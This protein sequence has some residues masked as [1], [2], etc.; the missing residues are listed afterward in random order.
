MNQA[1]VKG[2]APQKKTLGV[3]VSLSELLHLE[4]RPLELTR[5]L[6][7]I[8]PVV[9]TVVLDAFAS[10]AFHTFD[11]LMDV[12]CCLSRYKSTRRFVK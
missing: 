2:T 4:T 11:R 6:E 9:Y 7:N 12:A 3:L 1:A 8:D 10:Y 5:D